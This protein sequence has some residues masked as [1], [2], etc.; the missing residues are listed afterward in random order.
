MKKIKN[1]IK[2]RLNANAD[3]RE[4]ASGCITAFLSQENPTSNELADIRC[5]V[6]EAIAN[7]YIHAYK[8]TSGRN[9]IYLSARL[10]ENYAFT[11]EISDNGCGFDLERIGEDKSEMGFCVMRNFMDSIDVKSKIGKGTTVLMK[12]QLLPF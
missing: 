4:I 2:I 1:E 6:G 5:A 8:K 7:A 12:K 10:Y 3:C 11:V 9:F